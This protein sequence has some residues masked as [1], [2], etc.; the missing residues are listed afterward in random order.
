MP[1][2]RKRVPDDHPLTNIFRDV[3][4]ERTEEDIDDIFDFSENELERDDIDVS[5]GSVGAATVEPDGFL[6]DDEFE[7]FTEKAKESDKLGFNK[8]SKDNF[9]KSDELSTPKPIN[10]HL[11]RDQDTVVADV[12]RKATVTTD[13]AKYAN[14]PERFDFPFVDTPKEFRDEFEDTRRPFDKFESMAGEDDIFTY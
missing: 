5:A 2:G 13:P 8:M 1:D 7:T 4:V 14:N 9:A 3:D 11:D 10:T 6:D 12:Q